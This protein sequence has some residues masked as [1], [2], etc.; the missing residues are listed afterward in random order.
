MYWISLVLRITFVLCLYVCFAV[1]VSGHL[2][3]DS[4]R[5]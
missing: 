5:Y 4:A 3:V 1:Y 2:A